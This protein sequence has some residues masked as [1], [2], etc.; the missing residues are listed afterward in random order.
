MSIGRRLGAF[1]GLSFRLVLALVVSLVVVPPV[2]VAV[3]VTTLMKAPLPGELPEQQDAFVAEPSIVL[4]AAGN[5][6]GL[7]RGF[8]RTVEIQAS[9]VPDVMKSTIVAIEDARFWEHSGVDFEGIARAARTN[10]EVGGIAQGGSTI[11]QQYVKNAFLSGEQTLERKAREAQFAVELEQRLT[12]EEILFGYLETSYYGSGAYGIGAAA[13]LYFGKDVSDL[14]IGE[15]ATLAGVVQAPSRLSPR[16]DI[17]AA[18]ARRRLV[19]QAM[20]DQGYISVDEFERNVDRT[21][22]LATDGSR[23][24]ETVTVVVPLAPKGASQFPYFVDWVEADLLERLG[25][26][27]LYRGGLTIETTIN[28]W[29][30]ALAE[31]SVAEQLGSTEYPVEMSLVSIDPQNGHVVAMVGGR[32]YAASQVNLATGGTTGFQ[33]G[34]SFKPIVLAEAFSK[35]IGPDTVYPAPATWAVPGCSGSQCVISNYDNAD[36]GNISLTDATR[37]SVNTV[38]AEL[39][40]DVSVEDTLTLARRL[41]L[42]RLDPDGY[43]GASLA[44]GAGESSTLEMASAYG[45]FANSGVRVAPTGIAMVRDADGNVLIDNRARA[46][47]RVL[48]SNVADN[49]TKVLETVVVDGTGQRA[50]LAGGRPVAGK[51]GTAQSYTAA[52]FVGYTP[53]LAT[54]VWMGH[55]DGLAPLRNINGIGSVTGGSFPAI[56]F[57]SYMNGALAGTDIVPFPVPGPIEQVESAADVVQ[58]RQEQTIVGSKDTKNAIVANCGG[59]CTNSVV[60]TPVLTPPPLAASPTT[61]IPAPTTSTAPNESTTTT[62]SGDGP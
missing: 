1:V 12:K 27:V 18:D 13:E 42:E 49:V 7:F 20:L 16:E 33:P 2:A 36:R 24:S 59:P 38:F 44:L 11:T 4:D 53:Q 54:A 28:P 50:A 57:S 55:A 6:I 43:Y 19:L 23:P 56:A 52:W 14:D 26:D 62:S 45:T 21:L 29:L 58:R 25:P 51:T 60:P 46:G 31:Q 8:E 34:S 39:I 30:Q 37:A 47:D 40:T 41:G 5:E 3:G 35:G 17:E 32:D 61:T 10:L 15:A 48:T 9:D 22:W